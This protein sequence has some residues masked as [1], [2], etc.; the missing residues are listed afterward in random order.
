GL[1]LG[2]VVLQ[3]YWRNQPVPAEVMEEPGHCEQGVSSTIQGIVLKIHAFHGQTVNA[4]DPL[5]TLRPT[6]ELLATAQSSLLKSVQEIEQ[7]QFELKRITSVADS[8]GIPGARKI[9][10]EFELKRLESQRLN[11]TQELLGRGLTP[12]QI[13]E[14]V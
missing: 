12:D 2:P 4:G 9:E 13:E 8:G 14:I 6:S 5:V 10:K 11:L 1:E 3:D 7:V